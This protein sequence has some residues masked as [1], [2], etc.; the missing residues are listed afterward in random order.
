LLQCIYL[1]L[2]FGKV[3]LEEFLITRGQ[4]ITHTLIVT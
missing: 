3:V 4:I 2:S 1:L